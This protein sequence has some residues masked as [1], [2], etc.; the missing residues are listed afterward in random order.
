MFT[1]KNPTSPDHDFG[2]TGSL[3]RGEG[4]RLLFGLGQKS[5]I[6]WAVEAATGTLAWNAGKIREGEGILGD[7]ATAD[8]V[9]V[10]PYVTRQ[11]LAGIDAANGTVLWERPFPGAIYADP[12]IVPGAA[13]ATDTSGAIRAFGLRTG[14]ML[15]NAS[16]ASGSVFGGLSVAG[17]RLFVPVVEDGFLGARGAVVAYGVTRS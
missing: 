4:G 15:W 13:I 8:G 16:L 2:S 17:G 9:V 7:S 11:V 6:Y 1:Q 5:S 12:V 3:F 14:E 10:V